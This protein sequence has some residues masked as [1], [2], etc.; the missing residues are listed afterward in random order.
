MRLWA[1]ENS[2]MLRPGVVIAHRYVVLQPLGE[3]ATAIVYRACDRTEGREVALKVLGVLLGAKVLATDRFKSPTEMRE[4]LSAVLETIERD[5]LLRDQMRRRAAAARS[6]RGA[7][8]ILA[9]VAVVLVAMGT[10]MVFGTAA[11]VALW[12]AGPSPAPDLAAVA[13]ADVLGARE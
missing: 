1:D 2:T 13:L 9:A 8:R 6:A 11:G 7:L 12:T 10:T 5:S 4:A 3:G